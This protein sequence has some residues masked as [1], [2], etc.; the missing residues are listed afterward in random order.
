MGLVRAPYRAPSGPRMGLDWATRIWITP[1]FSKL[2][3]ANRWLSKICM[4]RDGSAT[5]CYP[6][7]LVCAKRHSVTSSSALAFFYNLVITFRILDKIFMGILL[8]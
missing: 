3:A 2:A 7:F 5:L 8:S 4:Q 1:C 6:R